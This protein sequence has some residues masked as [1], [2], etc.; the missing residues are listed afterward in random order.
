M[1][2]SANRRVVK[3]IHTILNDFFTRK[4]DE[5]STTAVFFVFVVVQNA[6]YSIVNLV[7]NL[8]A[9]AVCSCS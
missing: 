3:F 4:E 8:V 5:D 2:L 6:V 1:E 9:A 7:E